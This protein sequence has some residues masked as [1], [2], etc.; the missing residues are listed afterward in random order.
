[1]VVSKN[2]QLQTRDLGILTEAEINKRA[3][4]KNSHWQVA[5][6]IKNY[7]NI[8]EVAN[9]QLDGARNI[10]KLKES[11]KDLD[12]AIRFWSVLGLVVTTQKANAKTVESILLYFREALQDK[13]ISVQLTAAEGLCNLGYYTEAIDVLSQALIDPSVSAR[14]RSACILD[15]QPS[16]ANE[17]LQVAVP[18][19]KEAMAKTN[20][21]KMRGIPYGLNAPFSRAL[22][23]I[24]GEKNYYRWGM[25]ASGT[26]KN[27]LMKVQESP[28]VSK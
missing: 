5:N 11:S 6:K 22:K 15:S 4:G 7:K 27:H 21:R 13:S 20:V 10:D 23:A 17:S 8:L 25:G 18:F 16:E 12:P 19:L 26:P 28:F 1:L 24:T 9:M 3:M 2:W 14:I